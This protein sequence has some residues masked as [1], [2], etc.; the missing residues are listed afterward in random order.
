MQRDKP[1]L[2]PGLPARD[3]NPSAQNAGPDPLRQSRQKA[4]PTTERLSAPYATHGGE[5]FNPFEIANVNTAEPRKLLYT[6]EDIT[7]TY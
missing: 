1:N 6:Y 3:Y 4:M 7:P 5:K 2:A